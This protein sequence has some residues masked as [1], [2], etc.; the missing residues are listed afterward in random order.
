MFSA[1]TAIAWPVNESLGTVRKK[2]LTIRIVVEG[3]RRR[4]G[5]A[6][7]DAGV[8]QFVEHL[9]GDERRCRADDR[10][11]VAGQELLDSGAGSLTDVPSL[12]VTNC[13]GW[14]STPPASLI[15]LMPT[16]TALIPARPIR[17]PAPVSGSSVPIVRIPS[18]RAGDDEVG[19]SVDGVDSGEEG[20]GVLDASP[21]ALAGLAA[22]RGSSTRRAAPRRRSDA[23]ALVPSGPSGQP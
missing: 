3:E 19:R 12:A 11:D 6:D 9:E 13:T 15:A 4:R 18:A 20:G 1:T 22:T 7:Q 8:H 17:L 5:G 21:G 14:P 23:A 2:R 10:V 16:V